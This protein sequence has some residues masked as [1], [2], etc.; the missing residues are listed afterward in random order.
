MKSPWAVA[1]RFTVPPA[2][3]PSPGGKGL[4]GGSQERYEWLPTTIIPLCRGARAA[5]LLAHKPTIIQH[6]RHA[7]SGIAMVTSKL[8]GTHFSCFT[9]PR[10]RW[11]QPV[12]WCEDHC[13]HA[14][15]LP[16][17]SLE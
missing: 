15:G 7:A 17:A 4:F 11:P 6:A 16:P 2:M 9:G 14:Q 8:T 3:W 5:Q 12:R 13:D 10:W 1:Q